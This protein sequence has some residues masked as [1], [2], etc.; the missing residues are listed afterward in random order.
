MRDDFELKRIS[1]EAV[2]R[3]VERAEHYR[4]LNDPGPAESI[5]LDVLEVDPEHQRAIVCLVLAL[6]D[7]FAASGSTPV[8]RA[9][10]T[11]SRL[12]DPYERAYYLGIIHEREGRAY[13][14]R[15]KAGRFAYQALRDA[16][17]SYE[18]AEKL[19][20]HGND[21]ALLRF[22]SC[23]RTIQSENLEPVD[24][25]GELPLE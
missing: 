25:H 22:N 9:R 19:R 4:L 17:T 2:E 14:T 20:P 3:A 23:V 5:C 7:R 10:Q 21:D 8:S 16:M 6:T 18:E 11:A 24:D 15:G 13:L 12:K 1:T